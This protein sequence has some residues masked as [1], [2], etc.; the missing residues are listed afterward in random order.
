M[1]IVVDVES[2]QLTELLLNPAVRKQLLSEGHNLLTDDWGNLYNVVEKNQWIY[3]THSP[4]YGWF[5][6]ED[7]L[8]NGWAD[9][10]P[11]CVVVIQP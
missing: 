1:L 9:R 10:K 7:P 4:S 6:S 11:L 2:K 5:V 3:V 8:I